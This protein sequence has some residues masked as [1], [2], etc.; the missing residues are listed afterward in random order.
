MT[1]LFDQADSAVPLDTD[2]FT[3]VDGLAL[4]LG[5]GSVWALMFSCVLLVPKEGRVEFQLC[6]D[7]S[8][9]TNTTRAMDVS[10]FGLMNERCFCL[11]GRAS[12]SGGEEITVKWRLTKG[13]AVMGDRRLLLFQ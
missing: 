1:V 12:F 8:A 7:G 3:T 2:T 11:E 10:A 13:K 6:A 5:A 4:T 9:I